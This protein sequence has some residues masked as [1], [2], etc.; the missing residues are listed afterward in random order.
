MSDNQSALRLEGVTKSFKGTVVLDDID[1]TVNKGEVVGIIGSNGSGKTTLLRII[2]GLTYPDKG[3]VIVGQNKV[4]PGL[5]GN[6]PDKVGAL[7]EHPQFLP[8]FTGFQN[9]SFLAA[10]RG[11][12][13]SSD[14]AAVMQ[15][16][17][18][19]P[20][21]KKTVNKYSLGMKQRLGIAQAVME[22]PSLVL[23][24]EPTNGLDEEGVDRFSSIVKSMVSKGAAFV[25]VSH[26]KEDI[27]NLCSRVYKIE[28]GKLLPFNSYLKE[29]VHT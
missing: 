29:D 20:N 1:L 11:E 21:N 22:N 3:N 28:N 17:G 4:L 14:I 19:D 23:F 26:R 6:L 18:L 16:V 13:G 7:I 25:I 2:M 12:I 27:T 9:L 5:L 15:R 8:Q 10:I 24:D